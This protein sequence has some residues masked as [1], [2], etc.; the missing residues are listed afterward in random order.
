MSELLAQPLSLPCGARLHNR[1]AKAAMTEGLADP[2][3]IPTAELD[4]LY[5]LWSDGGA[6][7]LLTGNILVDGDHLE[8][9]GNVIIDREPDAAMQAALSRWCAVV[10]T[11]SGTATGFSIHLV[12]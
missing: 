5:G 6:G 12:R 9:P 10:L 4:R 11:T 1:L 7:L 3:G 2:A 8:R